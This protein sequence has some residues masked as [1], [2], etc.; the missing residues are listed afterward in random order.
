[1]G[2]VGAARALP[3]MAAVDLCWLPVGAR[4][5]RRFR[6]FRYEIRVWRG[7]EIPDVAEAVESP[8]RLSREEDVARRVLD[9]VRRVPTPVHGLRVFRRRIRR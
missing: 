9:V 6:I 7:G 1:M 3:A 8:R 4:W 5:A 2:P